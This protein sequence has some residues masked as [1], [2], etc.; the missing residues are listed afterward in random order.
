MTAAD[1]QSVLRHFQEISL[2]DLN[3]KAALQTRVDRKYVLP[4][5]AAK[6]LLS[7]LQPVAEVLKIADSR[8][9]PYAS[10]Y[11]DTPELESYHLAA[12]GRRRRFK[13]R[14][15]TYVESGLSFIEVKTKGANKVTVKERVPY[16]A[17]DNSGLSA[18]AQNYVHQTLS[19]GQ[20][21]N[22]D[23]SA[24]KPVLTT[25]YDRSTLL[26]A[27]DGARA[28]FDFGLTISNG[29]TQKIRFDHLVVV[30]TKSGATPQ[31]LT[32]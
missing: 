29:T 28:T 30:E 13:V 5:E 25:E 20:I 17:S 27:K 15:R 9:H 2:E 12:F 18:E 16:L 21:T 26:I 7:Q 10:T 19:A 24:F 8:S 31:W 6:D 4:V 14:A 32:D 1:C 11:F 3:A 22:V 23:V